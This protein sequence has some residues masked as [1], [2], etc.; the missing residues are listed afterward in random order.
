MNWAECGK[1]TI[2]VIYRSVKRYSREWTNYVS[3]E[4]I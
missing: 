4:K 1:S 2:F 3:N